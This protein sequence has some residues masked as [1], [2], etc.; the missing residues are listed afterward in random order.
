MPQKQDA[1]EKK[2]AEIAANKATQVTKQIDG[3]MK[4]KCVN[5][6]E[7]HVAG[8]NNC[9]NEKK[10]RVIEKM[11]ANSRVG[12]QRALQIQAGEDESPRSNAQ[13]FPTHFACKMDPENKITFNPWAIEK[14]LTQ[15][16]RSTNES[17]KHSLRGQD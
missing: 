10:E 3:Q 17:Q 12:R 6:G 15:K 11:Q 13:S 14:S 5:C 7:G 4:L 1:D 9:E 16:K 2:F 8:S